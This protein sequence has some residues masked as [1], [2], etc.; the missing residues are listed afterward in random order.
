MDGTSGPYVIVPVGQLDQVRKIL[1]DNDIPHWADH[2]AISIDGRSAVI[3]VNLGRG[4]DP[5][6][7]QALLDERRVRATPAIPNMMD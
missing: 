5:R 7:T 2:N 3:A 1:Q 4:I 6:R